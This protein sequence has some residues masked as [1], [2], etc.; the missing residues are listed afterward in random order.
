MKVAVREGKCKGYGFCADLAPN[1]YELD[2]SGYNA[3][4]GQPPARVPAG[5]EGEAREGAEA[6]P[7]RALVV[8]ESDDD[9]SG[10]APA[11]RR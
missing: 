9:A 11:P 5:L 7:L 6:C 3:L 1:A 2:G 8:E 4:V 10:P